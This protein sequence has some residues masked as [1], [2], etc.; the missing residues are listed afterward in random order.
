M[1]IPDRRPRVDRPRPAPDPRAGL[2]AAGAGAQERADAPR[3]ARPVGGPRPLRGGEPRGEDAG[4][5]GDA[6]LARPEGEA[7]AGHDGRS[8]RRCRSSS[9][10]STARPAASPTRHE[11][12]EK[13]ADAVK[14]L[15]GLDTLEAPPLRR[16]G[17]GVARR[18][19]HAPDGRRAARD[20]R[21][22]PGRGQD[23][24]RRP[25]G[26]FEVLE[27]VEGGKHQVSTC[28]GAPAVLGWATG[29]LPEPKNNPQVGMANM[30]TVMPALQKAAPA[31][32][33]TGG[34]EFALGAAAQGAARDAD[35]EGRE[36]RRDGERDRRVDLEGLGT[37]GEHDH[38]HHPAPDALRG[39]RRRSRSAALE[40]LS[41]AKSLGGAGDGRRLRRR[42]QKPPRRRSPA[43]APRRCSPSPATPSR[44]PRYATDAA[45]ADR[46]REGLRR[47][48]SSSRPR[49]PAWP[50]SPP[51]SRSGS[52]GRSTRTSRSS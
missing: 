29:S 37:R 14:A 44:E 31:P 32:V 48:A 35:R 9:S 45:A 19:R 8:P 2:D 12:A 1:S 6:R 23:R 38:G 46:A 10:R 5:E 42:R 18:G 24:R 49:P 22:V 16:L 27:R 36:P 43:P 20:R 13:L 33:T 26:S 3:G 47:A 21:A 30:R 41:A 51:A 39:R 15:P 17:V 7:A 25:D 34:V 40:A 50:A 28:A 52:A 4:L 11:V